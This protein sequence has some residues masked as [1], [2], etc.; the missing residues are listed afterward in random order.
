MLHHGPG[1]GAPELLEGQA[2]KLAGA[3]SQ[4]ETRSGCGTGAADIVVA[5]RQWKWVPEAKSTIKTTL[6]PHR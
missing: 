2:S 6:P 3:S 1:E 5:K 4:R